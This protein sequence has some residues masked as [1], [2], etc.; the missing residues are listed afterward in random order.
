DGHLLLAGHGDAASPWR[1]GGGGRALENGRK[2]GA[3]D[4][5][6][7]NIEDQAEAEMRARYPDRAGLVERD[8]VKLHYEVFGT[9]DR[10]IFFL[11]TWSIIHSH[12]WKSQVPYFARH[13]RVLTFDGRENGL[14]DRPTR[15]EAYADEE[16]AADCL[17]VM[18]ATNT[19]RAIVVGLSAGARWALL[20]AAEHPDRV[21]GT[22]FVGPSVRLASDDPLRAAVPEVT[23]GRL[24][25]MKGSG[26]IPLARDPVKFNLLLRDFVE[27]APSPAT[28]VRGRS[29]KKRALFISS[30]IGLGHAQRDVVIADELRRLHPGLEIDWLAQHPVTAVLTARGERIHP[31]SQHLANESR[32][33]EGESAEHDLHC[34]QA[35]RR[36]DEIMVANFMVFHDLVSQEPYDLWIGDEAWEVDYYL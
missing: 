12:F 25:T 9:G 34:F 17:A 8:G 29:R 15:P 6:L 23:G 36:M 18:N 22:A 7:G 24:V 5:A 33:L 31:M 32:H 20:L 27:P 1:A 16:F 11:P 4:G 3:A 21:L 26:H 14:S 28:W 35:W 30:P 10:T 2:A 19:E 13:F